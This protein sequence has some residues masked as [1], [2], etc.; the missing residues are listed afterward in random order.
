LAPELAAVEPTPVELVVALELRI[1]ALTF[2]A[3]ADDVPAFEVT[4]GP[5]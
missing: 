5:F 1:A 2:A 3:V 4:E